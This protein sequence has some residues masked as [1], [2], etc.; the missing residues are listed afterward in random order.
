MKKNLKK[1]RKQSV[2]ISTEF[3]CE[4]CKEHVD[5]VFAPVDAILLVIVVHILHKCCV[6]TDRGQCAAKLD[7]WSDAA[8][9]P[10][11][12]QLILIFIIKY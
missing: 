11:F 6:H 12:S 7:L 2:I 9:M 4:A 1:K 10:H 3:K 8:H 5:H